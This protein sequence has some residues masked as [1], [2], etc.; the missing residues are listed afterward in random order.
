MSTKSLNKL[1]KR[2]PGIDEAGIKHYTALHAAYDGCR[3][4]VEKYVRD[5]GDPKKGTLSNPTWN[6]ESW[7]DEGKKDGKFNND[8][9]SSIQQLVQSYIVAEKPDTSS[10][11]A[12]PAPQKH[13]PGSGSICSACAHKNNAL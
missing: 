1:M 2:H 13:A 5:G 6:L 4:C 9:A 7:V 11:T 8:Q 10:T 3:A 12:A